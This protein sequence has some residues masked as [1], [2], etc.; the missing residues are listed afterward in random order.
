MHHR[1]FACGWITC[2]EQDPNA[3][4]TPDVAL[5]TC[6][7]CIAEL[8]ARRISPD[9]HVTDGATGIRTSELTRPVRV[10]RITV[11]GPSSVGI[12]LDDD[13]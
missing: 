12:D 1:R 3:Q 7:R 11:S 2:G 6:P 9:L 5:V 13:L 4:D 8:N 10:E